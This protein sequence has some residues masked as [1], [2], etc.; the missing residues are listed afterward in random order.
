[1]LLLEFLVEALRDSLDIER[2]L[3]AAGDFG[4]G[5]VALGI[6][7]ADVHDHRGEFAEEEVAGLAFDVEMVAGIDLRAVAFHPI[8]E[9]LR[10]V[11]IGEDEEVLVMELGDFLR[12]GG[13]GFAVG[14]RGGT[15]DFQ[16][17]D[18]GEMGKLSSPESEAAGLLIDRLARGGIGPAEFLDEELPEIEVLQMLA[19]AGEVEG[20][21]LIGFRVEP[22]AALGRVWRRCE[23]RTQFSVKIAKRLIVDKERLVDL[24]EAFEDGAVGGE[25][26]ANLHE[27]ADDVE[28]HLDRLGAA[29]NIGCLQRAVLGEDM[30]QVARIAMLLGTGHNL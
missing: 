23:Q 25:F 26:L 10:A 22:N 27:G 12:D 8:P 3:E 5:D 6:E 21:T 11:G 13:A 14:N 1:M 18:A 16:H 7:L 30:G 2:G 4:D 24:G 20:H 29:E 9:A 15:G 19:G 28:A 17:D